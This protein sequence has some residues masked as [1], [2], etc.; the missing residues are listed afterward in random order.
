MAGKV[1]CACCTGPMPVGCA[2]VSSPAPAPLCAVLCTPLVL[3][4]VLPEAGSP[5]VFHGCSIS[6]VIT[7]AKSRIT[8]EL[9]ATKPANEGFF[10]SRRLAASGAVCCRAAGAAFARRDGRRPLGAGFRPRAGSGAQAAL[11]CP[12]R[13][14]PQAPQQTPA[15]LQSYRAAGPGRGK[16]GEGRRAASSSLP[17]TAPLSVLGR[18]H[19]TTAQQG[20]TP[21]DM[22]SLYPLSHASSTVLTKRKL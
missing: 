5:A 9:A 20:I 19:G 12:A 10:F 13:A 1:P 18:P 15:A 14:G 22:H 2:A 17:C 4:A 21:H 16:G 3:L 6:S 8:A 11:H 7:P